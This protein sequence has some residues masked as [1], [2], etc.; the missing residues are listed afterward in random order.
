[1]YTTKQIFWARIVQIRLFFLFTHTC[2]QLAEY[3]ELIP[4]EEK[5]MLEDEAQG[6]THIKKAMKDIE[7]IKKTVKAISDK[8][9]SEKSTAEKDKLDEVVTGLKKTTDQMAVAI[10]EARQ[11]REYMKTSQS[12]AY[13]LVERRLPSAEGKRESDKVHKCRVCRFT[14]DDEAIVL[15][16]IWIYYRPP[17]EKASG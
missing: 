5:K 12:A 6:E 10:D 14:S 11:G 17:F 9:V 16:H 15:K 3:D 2:L 8:V 13:E 7:E 1:M 4:A